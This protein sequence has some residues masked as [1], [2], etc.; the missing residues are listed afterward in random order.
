MYQ[1]MFDMSQS[2]DFSLTEIENMIPV[3]RDVYINMMNERAKE[4][5]APNDNIPW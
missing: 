1:T 4:A 3:E 2:A 5:S